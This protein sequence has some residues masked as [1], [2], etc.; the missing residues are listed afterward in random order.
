MSPSFRLLIFLLGEFRIMHKK[1][2]TG[3]KIA[4]SLEV[5]STGMFKS[6][7]I[8]REEDETL[9]VF[10]KSIPHAL[11]GMAKRNRGNS[12]G[13]YG[14]RLLAGFVIE[15]IGSYIFK[16]DGEVGRRHDS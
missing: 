12:H 16:F 13:F 14:E 9:T 7:F 4:I 2:C 10:R 3:G 1:V 6:Q 8:V 11:I 15:D 5:D